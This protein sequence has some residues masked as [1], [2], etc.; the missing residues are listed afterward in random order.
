MKE[1][2]GKLPVAT[3]AQ[4][5]QLVRKALQAGWQ[6]ISGDGKLSLEDTEIKKMKR[7]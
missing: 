6:R 5:E 7:K 2:S 4:Q 1:N 3:I